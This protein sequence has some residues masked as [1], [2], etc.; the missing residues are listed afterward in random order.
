MKRWAG[1]GVVGGL[2]AA[3]LVGSLASGDGGPRVLLVGKR[4]DDPIVAR[5]AQEL[6]VLGL[7]VTFTASP[8]GPPRR[9]ASLAHDSSAAAAA[10]VEG[11]PPVVVLW[12]DPSR[13]SPGDDTAGA[14]IR[15]DEAVTGSSDPS[16]LALRAV[17]V[18]RGR[19]IPV[20]AASQP[21]AAADAPSAAAAAVPLATSPVDAQAIGAPDARPSAAPPPSAKVEP[22]ASAAPNRLE[23]LAGSLGPALSLSPG[24]V[25]ASLDLA[26]AA[27]WNPTGHVELELLGLLPVTAPTVSSNDGA[28]ELRAYAI[29]VGLGGAFATASKR[30]FGS[31]SLGLGAM[32]LVYRGDAAPPLRSA[33]GGAWAALPYGRIGGGYVVAP[34]LALRLDLLVA[35]ARPQPVLRMGGQPVADFGDPMVLLAAGLEVRP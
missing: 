12:V 3:M 2:V 16:L 35:V 14:E 25:P 6:R 5:M 33:E 31:A 13:A 20:P 8:G 21:D 17:E 10:R 11:E 26:L 9:L 29:A 22:A 28:M 19:L 1:A 4:E 18:L 7:E 34:P 24:G 23:G 32:R 27:R 30:A 15:L